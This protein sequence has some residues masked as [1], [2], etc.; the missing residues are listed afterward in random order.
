MA[1]ESVVFNQS[2]LDFFNHFDS[3]LILGLWY[4]SLNLIINAFSLGL[5]WDMVQEKGS[6]ERCSSCTELHAQTTTAL[7]SGFPLSQGNADRWSRRTKHRLIS[8]FLSNTCAKNYRNRFVY[9]KI[10]ASQMWDVFETQYGWLYCFGCPQ[11]S[12]RLEA[13][14]L[15]WHTSATEISKYKLLSE[16]ETAFR[17]RN[18]IL[19]NQIAKFQSLTVLRK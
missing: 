9:V 2:L 7:S 13:L 1:A 10:I 14:D 11:Y 8:Y 4:D 3:Q 18:H 19:W 12:I 6:R 5:L 15:W 16:L 17:D